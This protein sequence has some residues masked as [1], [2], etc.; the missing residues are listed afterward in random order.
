MVLLK[1]LVLIAALAV[2]N[3]SSEKSVKFSYHQPEINESFDWW[4]TAV[5]YQIYPRSYKDNN[6]DGDGDLQGITQKLSYL[7]DTGINAI[8]LSPI[9]KS[10]QI[11]NGYDISDYRDIDEIYGSLEDLRNLVDE[12]H[13][14]GLKVILDYV[15][16]HTSDQHEWFQASLNKQ[17]GYEDYYVWKDPVIV[18]GQ[19]NPP[20]NWV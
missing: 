4:Q 16:N 5:F 20:N 15:P 12:A 11:D 18:D 19:R 9:Y 13:K 8:W 7:R 2:C 17:P 10:P 3:V 14:L 6:N 1:V